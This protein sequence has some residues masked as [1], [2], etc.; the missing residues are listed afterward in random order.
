MS[1]IRRQRIDA[2][3]PSILD[4]V[5]NLG[6]RTLN[7]LS[8]PGRTT[9]KAL[10]GREWG[11]E[12][13]RDIFGLDGTSGAI[14]GL[15]IDILA[16]PFTYIGLGASK[17]GQ[18][19]KATRLAQR[20]RVQEQQLAHGSDV[21]ELALVT[22][23]LNE[24]LAKAGI[25]RAGVD[26]LN[27]EFES[28][29]NAVERFIARR[30]GLRKGLKKTVR[31]EPL[32]V[33]AREINT[34]GK[35][36]YDK[37][38]APFAALGVRL[39]REEKVLAKQLGKSVENVREDVAEVTESV[40][41][42]TRSNELLEHDLRQLW[43]TTPDET[44]EAVR[45]RALT[46][47]SAKRELD[48]LEELTKGLSVDGVNPRFVNE[49]G[50]DF[51]KAGGPRKAF[52]ESIARKVNEAFDERNRLINAYQRKLNSTDPRIIKISRELED[53]FDNMI[54]NEL[55]SLIDIKRLNQDDRKLLMGYLTH[56]ATPEFYRLMQRSPEPIKTVI[57]NTLNTSLKNA[58]RRRFS[59]TIN[60]MNRVAVEKG[61]VKQ[62][63]KILSDDY[64]ELL[65]ARALA[66]AEAQA[67]AFTVDAMVQTFASASE[68]G[69]PLANFL[70]DTNRT[71]VKMFGGT[72]VEWGEEIAKQSRKAEKAKR[73]LP[74]KAKRNIIGK[75]LE[76]AG[77]EGLTIPREFL[78]DLNVIERINLI[79]KERNRA[80]DLYQSYLTLLRSYVTIPFPAYHVRNS[81][82]NFYNG[83]LLTGVAY[84]PSTL[85][86]FLKGVRVSANLHFGKHE[87]ELEG[88]LKEVVELGVAGKGLTYEV[89]DLIN[90]LPARTML[91]KA[92]KPL[93][94]GF[95]FGQFNEDAARIGL[96]MARRKQ[97]WSKAEALANVHKYL[98]DYAHGLTNAEKSIRR[99]FAFFY[100][101]TRFNIPLQLEHLLSPSKIYRS[102]IAVRLP[103][104]LP[105]NYSFPESLE[106]DPDR[107]LFLSQP[108]TFVGLWDSDSVVNLGLSVDDLSF[109]IEGQGLS[110]IL[111]KSAV[112]S[113]NPLLKSPLEY[114][115]Q[116]DS[117]LGRDFEHLDRSNL[118]GGLIDSIGS[119]WV[120]EFF[121]VR[122]LKGGGY[123]MN[124]SWQLLLD[125][126]PTT[127]VRSIA[128]RGVDTR[129]TPEERIKALLWSFGIGATHKLSEAKKAEEKRRL[130]RILAQHVA[131]GTAR[132]GQYFYATDP[133]NKRLISQLNKELSNR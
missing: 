29:L 113:L 95:T 90:T 7:L 36:A 68:N 117:F 66:S 52:N 126:F 72:K 25:D 3:D 103:G 96:Y 104:L 46:D 8:L 115:F 98:F 34:L 109:G 9:L 63:E 24:Q 106:R 85:A 37:A 114:M 71:G 40:F 56:R 65:V 19:K 11:H 120:N 118:Y 41:G 131:E 89:R 42:L 132:R 100:T 32:S 119:D 21:A 35:A 53:A 81:L 62:G 5:V 107:P 69:V 130:R 31:E 4:Y 6:G 39:K 110:G 133:Q 79:P 27:R 22:K 48:M 1:E 83:A 97:G 80:V 82:G 43:K 28:G 78:D 58:K 10:T 112:G 86:E 38:L 18:V 70:A 92:T 108:G 49:Y 44:I 30:P 14:T 129:L 111:R 55:E 124:K 91:A 74:T 116:K 12:V 2:P 57:R 47:P 15:G 67:N 60:E 88:I 77:F 87:K 84:N 50:S 64:S 128:E 122:K 54:T 102:N 105:N 94:P 127:R 99:N 73:K 51:L 93:K 33:G 59:G 125:N 45:Q 16:D 23:R 121:G 26:V 75:K 61:W 17:I 101:W 20:L 76:E 123:R 13:A